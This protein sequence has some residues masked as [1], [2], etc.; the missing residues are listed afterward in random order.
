MGELAVGKLHRP[1]AVELLKYV[2]RLD[3]ST[4]CTPLAISC[5]F[6]GISPNKYGIDIQTRNFFL[7]LMTLLSLDTNISSSKYSF[8]HS[9][10]KPWL[11]VVSTVTRLGGF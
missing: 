9:T 11:G 5:P 6:L 1:T 2:L 8:Q 4:L 7:N 3:E 10:F